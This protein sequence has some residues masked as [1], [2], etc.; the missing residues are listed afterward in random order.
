MLE[1]ERVPPLCQCHAESRRY[2]LHCWSHTPCSRKGSRS[3]RCGSKREGGEVSE[4]HYSLAARSR[5]LGATATLVRKRPLTPSASPRRS[6]TRSLP[7]PSSSSAVSTRACLA[8]SRWRHS[9]RTAAWLG[10]GC[11][12]SA[13][14][15]ELAQF[16]TPERYLRLHLNAVPLRPQSGEPRPAPPYL[17]LCTGRGEE[18]VPTFNVSKGSDSLTV[19]SACNASSARP[20][21]SEVRETE[22]GC[23]RLL[24]SF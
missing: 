17:P 4:I 18:V 21:N 24:P 14:P 19:S 12:I 15:S 13:A 7:A 10:N 5:Q 20:T 8:G 22:A 11:A 9:P 23:A 2:R 3:S 16:Y 1:R 6:G